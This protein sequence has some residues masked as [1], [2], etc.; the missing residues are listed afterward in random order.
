MPIWT[1]HKASN[2]G[3][4]NGDSGV[5]GVPSG[6]MKLRANTQPRPLPSFELVIHRDGSIV[7]LAGWVSAGQLEGVLSNL[8]FRNARARAIASRCEV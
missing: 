6:P 7:R 3:L 5:G 8:N 4:L 2:R 1:H